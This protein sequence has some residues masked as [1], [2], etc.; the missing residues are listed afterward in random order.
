MGL[1][2]YEFIVNLRYEFSLGNFYLFPFIF[3]Q[4]L[5]PDDDLY[6]GRNVLHLR[7]ILFAYDD[8]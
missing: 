6:L 4:C 7:S 8:E 2:K 3:L 1:D 5:V